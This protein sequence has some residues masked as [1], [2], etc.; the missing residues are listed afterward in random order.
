M[1]I[2]AAKRSTPDVLAMVRR[3]SPLVLLVLLLVPL[4]MITGLGFLIL[5]GVVVNNS[6]LIVERALQLQ[7]EGQKYDES[8]FNATRDRLR[9]IFMSAGTTV[10]G[11]VRW[12]CFQARGQ[13]FTRGLALPLPADWHSPLF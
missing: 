6:I 8:I 3:R 5:T 1:K 9:P 13:S 7:D 4:D 11:M 2:L 12:R 10:L